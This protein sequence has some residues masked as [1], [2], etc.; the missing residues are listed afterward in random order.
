MIIGPSTRRDLPQG[1][2][3]PCA[4]RAIHPVPTDTKQRSL[5]PLTAPLTA[6][7]REAPEPLARRRARQRL[8]RILAARRLRAERAHASRQVWL[9]EHESKQR[10]ATKEQVV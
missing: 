7:A 8:Q 1:H 3:G 2:S 4:L 10:G 6:P 9:E 5:P